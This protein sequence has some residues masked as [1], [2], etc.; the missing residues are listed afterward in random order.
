M[1]VRGKRTEAEKRAKVK[2]QSKLKRLVV[3]LYP[4]DTDI[5]DWINQKG[6]YSVYI[7][8]LI[9]EDMAKH[10]REIRKEKTETV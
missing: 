9:R 4:K 2:Y 10:E 6:G 8:E 5:S 3:T 7:R 1:G